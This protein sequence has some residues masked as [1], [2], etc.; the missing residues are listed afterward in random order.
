MI[1]RGFFATCVLA[2]DKL[3]RGVTL[4]FLPYFYKID[5]HKLVFLNFSGNYDCNPKAICKRLLDEGADVKI[6]WGVY[7]DTPLSPGSFPPGVRTAVRETY[8]LYKELFTAR[9]IVD[10]GVSAATLRLHKKRGQILIETWHG[11]LGIKKF[12]RDSNKDKKWLRLAEKE[13][14]MTDFIISNSTFE[15]AIYREDFWK[16]TPVWRFGHPRNDVLFCN[17][18]KQKAALRQAL[19]RRF[20]IEENAQLCLYAPTFRDDGDLTPYTLDYD[21]L[22]KALGERFGGEWVILTRFHR[23]TRMML[24][25]L[26]PPAGVTDV[27]DYTDIQELLL[28]IDVG[29]TDYSSWICEYMLR[30]SP[31]FIYATDAEK[32]RRQ[33]RRLFFPLEALPFPA[34]YDED[35]LIEN[36]LRF[37]GARFRTDC[38]AF[39]TD[40][41]SVDDG[42]AAERTV[43]ELK[44]LM[45]IENNAANGDRKESR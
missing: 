22:R 29:I 24:P 8:A 37:D 26:T 5:P 25:G 21:R 19:N 4:R 18:A 32:Y 28:L 45:H 14:R 38:D 31:G 23:R 35:G 2:A 6:V 34:A 27:G 36:I 12:G 40:K 1:D 9:V 7:P 20:G 11:S 39:L 16:E 10:N 13:G 43:N 17:D 42:H 15:D 30:R 41:G 33:D 44:K 3:I